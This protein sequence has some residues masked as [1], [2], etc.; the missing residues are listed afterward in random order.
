MG[1]SLLPTGSDVA[2]DEKS[3]S[4]D[5]VE[6]RALHLTSEH[7][8][9]GVAPVDPSAPSGALHLRVPLAP[10]GRFS[11]LRCRVLDV[12]LDAPQRAH[13]LP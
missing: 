12:A 10:R 3:N 6:P 11:H 9:V 1:I 2:A 8:A 7:S 13:P 5:T 4:L